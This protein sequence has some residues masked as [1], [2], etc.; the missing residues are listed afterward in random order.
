MPQFF[1][2]G[3]DNST[4]LVN[5]FD[6]ESMEHWNGEAIPETAIT[7]AQQQQQQL[8][9][10]EADAHFEKIILATTITSASA[11]AS[12]SPSV[13]LVNRFRA[14]FSGVKSAVLDKLNLNKDRVPI[15]TRPVKTPF[16]LYRGHPNLTTLT[17]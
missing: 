8:E 11:P 3:L 16:T 13:S 14:T 9:E 17:N 12:A 4:Q 10:A 1:C 6:L 5:I 15:A 2:T 7:A